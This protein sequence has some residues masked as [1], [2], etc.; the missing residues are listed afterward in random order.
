MLKRVT[1]FLDSQSAWR[2]L[3]FAAAF[4][5]VAS[6]VDIVTGPNIR[7]GPLYL[8]PVVVVAW[9]VGRRWAYI[10]SVLAIATWWIT[11]VAGL[12]ESH[13]RS[14]DPWNVLIRVGFYYAVVWLLSSLRASR[15]L[16]E[17]KVRQRTVDLQG[18]VIERKRAEAATRDLAV[19]LSVAEDDQ[20]RRLAN[21]LHDA[22][23]QML[24]VLKLNLE[25]A[26]TE[27]P[28]D[29]HQHERLVDAVKTVDG[30]ITQTRSLT[31]ELHPSILDDLGLVPA[32]EWFSGQFRLKTLAEVSITEVGERRPVPLPLAS[33]LFRAVK[34]L[35]S[36][37]VKHGNAKEI[38][39][40][41]HW[42]AETLRIVVDDDGGGFDVAA[43]TRP[44]LR[45]GL[46]LASIE[47]RIGFLG[48]KFT[49]DS[50][51]GQGT[52]AIIEVPLAATI[53]ESADSAKESFSSTTTAAPTVTTIP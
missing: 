38:L 22:V 26:V 34:E 8:A 16:L 27:S 46:G 24:S 41:L 29:S 1:Q 5:A 36:N 28:V 18:E 42:L 43:A 39:V 17:D 7:V 45:R 25:T 49:L 4:L 9:F 14:Y 53:E 44:G 2:V 15:L 6:Y 21:E 47:E 35:A 52:R 37:G 12:P 10:L 13:D 30:L 33:Y 20:R 31:F 50:S 11:G 23:S 19:K 48:G 3:T 40:A 51:P 32:L